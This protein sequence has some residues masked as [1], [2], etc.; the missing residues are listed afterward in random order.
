MKREIFFTIAVFAIGV[1]GE[2]LA[3]RLGEIS[4]QQK[5]QIKCLE[6]NLTKEVCDK[7]FN[8]K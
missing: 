7:I 6:Q 5:S 3:F 8:E 1:W 2:M 4:S